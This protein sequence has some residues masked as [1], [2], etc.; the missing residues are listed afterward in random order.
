MEVPAGMTAGMEPAA[1]A[2]HSVSQPI[3]VH[4]TVVNAQG[5]VKF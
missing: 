1:A 5:L 4:I 2:L 3:P